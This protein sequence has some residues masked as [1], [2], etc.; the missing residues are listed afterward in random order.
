MRAGGASGLLWSV[1]MATPAPAACVLKDPGC[2]L[3]GLGLTETLSHN[4]LYEARHTTQRTDNTQVSQ[5]LFVSNRGIEM[6]WGRKYGVGLKRALADL[7][8]LIMQGCSH[9]SLA[10]IN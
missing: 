8:I 6:W 4:Q 9:P 2:G 7:H 1:K 3:W 10:Q 5:V